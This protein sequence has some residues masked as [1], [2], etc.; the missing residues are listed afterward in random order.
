MCFSASASFTAGA[1]LLTMGAIAIRKSSTPAQR[2]LSCIPIIFGL[3]Q[4]TEGL[5]WIGLSRPGYEYLVQ[6]AKYG[7][8]L[9]AQVVWPAFIP[10]SIMR[11]EPKPIRK[12]IM[13]VLFG[14]GLVLAAYFAYCLSA[15]DV[16]VAPGCAHIN[17]VLSYPALGVYAMSFGYFLPAAI[18]PFISGIGRLRVLGLFTLLAYVAAK[19]FYEQY[20]ISVWCF[21]AALVSGFVLFIIYGMNPKQPAEVAERRVM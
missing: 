16:T 12:K 11:I 19:I 15:C 2:V 10:Y 21:F 20:V 8:L 13:K 4:L 1:V 6:P 18:P 5:L 3:Q 7:F 9:F 17:Y 14:F